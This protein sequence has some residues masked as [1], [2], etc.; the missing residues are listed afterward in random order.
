MNGDVKQILTNLE[1]QM[2]QYAK[3]QRFEEA[4]RIKNRMEQLN[5]IHDRQIV[6]DVVGGDYDVLILLQKYKKVFAG[7]TQ[8]RN[9]KIVGVYHHILMNPGNESEDTLFQNFIMSKYI[10]EDW[11]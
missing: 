7:C 3:Q 11:S 4:A 9:G 6:R 8:I 1:N 5:Q 2:M 10:D